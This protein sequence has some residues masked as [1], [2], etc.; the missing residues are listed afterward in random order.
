M[1]SRAAGAQQRR[2]WWDQILADAEDTDTLMKL[3]NGWK[4][5]ECRWP[6]FL[7]IGQP[8]MQENPQVREQLASLR[9]QTLHVG[10]KLE[11]SQLIHQGRDER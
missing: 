8:R 7:L 6:R 2:F 11:V 10:R 1:R 4:S 9:Q 3:L 5:R